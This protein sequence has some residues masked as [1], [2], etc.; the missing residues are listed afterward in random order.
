[1]L[2]WRAGASA[3]SLL[4]SV[5]IGEIGKL[6]LTAV[7]FA[8]IFGAVRPLEPPAVFGGYIAAQMA[9]FGAALFGGARRTEA[10]TKS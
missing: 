3:A 8:A 4:R 1:M 7:L 2:Q 6:L 5:W 10:I 9:I